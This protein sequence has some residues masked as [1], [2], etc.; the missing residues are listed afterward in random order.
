VQNKFVFNLGSNII[1]LAFSIII[2]IWMTPFIVRSLGL[3]AFGFINLTQNLI[4]YLSIL[5]IA[6]SS[7]VSRFFTVAYQK[8][9]IHS[10]QGYINTYIFSSIAISGLITIPLVILSLFIDSIINVPK[11]LLLDV[12]IAILIGGSLF[13]LTFIGSAFSA[14]P[15]CFNKLYIN[16]VAQTASTI[17]RSISII[18]LL[19][20]I[21]PKIWF[22]NIA[23][24][25]AG[26]FSFLLG[27]YYF[28][29]LLPWVKLSIK[30]FEF[31]K[32]KEL[33]S[34]G[35]WNSVGQIGIILFLQIDLLVANLV[36]GAHLTGK[37]AAIIQ[38]P[39]LLRTLAGTIAAV[40]APLIVTL[41]A[42][43]DM[44]G[45]KKYSIQSVRLNGLMIS[46]PAA[47]LCGLGGPLLSVWLG[48]GYVDL[49]WLL[50]INS[51]YLVITLSVMP[52]FHIVTAMNK[53][54]LPGLVT[55]GFG[56]M[57]IILAVIF[58]GPMNLGLYGIAIAGAI[59][60]IGKN[61]IFTP[62]YCS[63]ITKQ[64]Y[65]VFYKGII[66]PL[67]GTCFA[68]IVCILL[69]KIIY[70]GDWLTFLLSC[71]VVSIFYVLFVIIFLLDKSEKAKCMGI[72]KAMMS[73]LKKSK[74]SRGSSNQKEYSNNK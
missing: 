69:Q 51:L 49:K 55:L 63:I 64:K 60:L 17:I 41:Y 22:V 29:K 67:L 61:F 54:K 16:N 43:N 5:T 68:S 7:V 66:S 65:Y 34:S 47:L 27:I 37:Y 12:R 35:G 24:L 71:T 18:L 44:E 25:I 70:I 62:I 33:L 74:I 45:L 15:F 40:F 23:A 2:S 26:V 19:T 50:I 3:E 8:G 32:L 13:I 58:S 72:F 39:M 30:Q 31:K 57:N 28:K 48:E 21:S 36:L 14:A 9:D 56:V 42:K 46:L 53:V 1:T 59:S 6:L 20:L 11:Y 52:L 38:F 73:R 4:S 10:A